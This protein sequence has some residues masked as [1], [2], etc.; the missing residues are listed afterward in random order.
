[1]YL[2]TIK[3]KRPVTIIMSDERYN[4]YKKKKNRSEILF[5]RYYT[6]KQLAK[7]K[8]YQ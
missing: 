7:L 2:L 5:A 1:M 3:G 8:R 6:Q 4:R